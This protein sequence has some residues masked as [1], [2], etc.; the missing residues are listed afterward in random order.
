M[1]HWNNILER[2][3]WIDFLISTDPI[4][5]NNSL[6]SLSKCVGSVEGWWSVLGLDAVQDWS[7]T[8]TTLLLKHMCKSS[9]YEK[10]GVCGLAKGKKYKI[11][12]F[13]LLVCLH[14][15]QVHKNTYRSLNQGVLN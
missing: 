5:I 7:H 14:G 15:L 2:V 13:E 12:H 10:L 6:D 3:T 11:F 8:G 4:G 9:G 1:L